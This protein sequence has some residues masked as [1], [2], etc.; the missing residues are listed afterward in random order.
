MILHSNK[1]NCKKMANIAKELRNPK[2]HEERNPMD[3]NIFNLEHSNL[4]LCELTIIYNYT[5]SYRVLISVY[6]SSILRETVNTWFE[7]LSHKQHVMH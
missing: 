5:Y 3:W 6:S 4:S 7:Y 2:I 1:K